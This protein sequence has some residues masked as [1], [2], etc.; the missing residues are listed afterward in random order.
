MEYTIPLSL[1][2]T[3]NEAFRYK[4]LQPASAFAQFTK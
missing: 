2:K 4:E 3:V 1:L